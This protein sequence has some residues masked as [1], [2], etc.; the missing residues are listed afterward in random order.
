MVALLLS[1]ASFGYAEEK[2]LVSKV[3]AW[4]L[5]ARRTNE[6]EPSYL[7]IKNKLQWK[8]YDYTSTCG[9]SAHF[10]EA[11]EHSG[12]VIEIPQSELMIRYDTYVSETL[13]DNTVYVVSVWEYPDK[14][15]IS[16][17]ELNL[18]E[19]FS[20][21][22]NALPESQVLLMKATEVQEHK[23]LEFWI[24]C[25][26]IYFRGLLISVNHTLYQ[27]FMVYKNEDPKALDSEYDMFTKSFK[28]TKVREAKSQHLKKKVCL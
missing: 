28:I 2:G 26:D 23:A 27:I 11:P 21:M 16:R 15:D 17:P 3:K 9:F 10:P 8:Y 24:V 22:L 18:Q 19:G 6:L 25:E 1:M 13:S 5:K 14:I 20:G 7:P 12:Q 4:F